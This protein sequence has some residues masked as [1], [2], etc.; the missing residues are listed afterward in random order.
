[1]KIIRV[2]PRPPRLDECWKHQKKVKSCSSSNVLAL[3]FVLMAVAV[4]WKF[5]FG[6]TAIALSVAGLVGL[7]KSLRQPP[8]WN[9]TKQLTVKFGWLVATLCFFRYLGFSPMLIVLLL[10]FSMRRRNSVENLLA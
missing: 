1:M 6:V 10:F 3:Y 7:W 5:A 2:N 9:Q 8:V 4:F